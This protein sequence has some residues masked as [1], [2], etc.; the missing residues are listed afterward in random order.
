[1][2]EE[3]AY[4]CHEQ[5]PKDSAR[6]FFTVIS[7]VLQYIVPCCIITFCYA[8]VSLALRSRARA[9]IGSS[10][11]SRKREQTEINRK[12]KTNRMLIAMVSIFVC[13][14]LPLN[15]IHLTLEYYEELYQHSY[16]LLVFF[17]THVIAMS[18]TVYNP[19]LYAWMNDNFKKE[20]RQVLPRLFPR[21]SSSTPMPVSVAA[22]AGVGR[23][24]GG[25]GGDG[26]GRSGGG[27]AGRNSSPVSNVHYTML[28]GTGTGSG[29]CPPVNVNSSTTTTCTTTA[30][31]GAMPTS[32]SH[33]EATTSSQRVDNFERSGGSGGG[34]A[35]SE[36]LD[37]GRDNVQMTFINN[38][39]CN[40]DFR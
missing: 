13:C 27:A 4:A 2:E 35:E 22:T 28:A 33:H 30:G 38:V 32:S 12:R 18:S 39:D 24:G 15:V 26:G 17:V 37:F 9:K 6:Q 23:G 29:S 8:M 34:G 1:M 10:S 5:W 20:F 7:L 40:D 19:F 14:W 36:R 31:G 11:N 3:G 16:F 25:G 21:A